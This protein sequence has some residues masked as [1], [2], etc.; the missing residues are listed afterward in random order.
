MLRKIKDFSGEEVTGSRIPLTSARQHEVLAE[1]ARCRQMGLNMRGAWWRS[2]GFVAGKVGWDKPT[3]SFDRKLEI[4]EAIR[5][6]LPKL[7]HW[8]RVRL[9]LSA[10]AYQPLLFISVCCQNTATSCQRLLQSIITFFIITCSG[11]MAW[12]EVLD[13]LPRVVLLSVFSHCLS[14]FWLGLGVVLKLCLY[15]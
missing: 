13:I 14:R 15:C 8:L 7:T 11:R 2:L 4:R 5:D 3:A 10:V 12:T 1:K 9:Y 6:C